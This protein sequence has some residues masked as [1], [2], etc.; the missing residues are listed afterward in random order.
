M[1]RITIRGADLY[2]EEHGAGPEAIV[3]AHGCLLSCRQFDGQLA[4][5]QDRYRC[6][7]FDFRGQGQSEVTRKGYD[8]DSLTEDVASLIRALGCSPCH[9]VGC[10][11]GG[12]VGMRLAVRHAD[13]LRSLTLVGSSASPEPSAWRF[14]LMCWTAWLLGVRAVT[15]WVMPV[16]F[17]PDFLRD[18]QR[19]AERQVWFERI[20]ATSRAGAVRAAG[21]VIARPDFAAP[22][23]QVRVPTLIVVGE[24]DRATPLAEARRLQRG[25]AGSELVVVPRAGHAVAIEQSVA[26]SQALGQFLERRHA[27]DQEIAAQTAP[28]AADRPRE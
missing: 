10:S 5:F 21:G 16:Q 24:A 12:F 2:F 25:I 17:G 11:M 22:L 6:I 28:V 3:F 14:R 7:A 8:M 1:A 9:F 20:A 13:L 26:V 15:P 23:S 4:T 18:P 27:H 19:S